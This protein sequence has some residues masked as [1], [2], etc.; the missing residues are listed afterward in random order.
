MELFA[1]KKIA[2]LL[3]DEEVLKRKSPVP[4]PAFINFDGPQGTIETASQKEM[5]L[6]DQKIVDDDFRELK[7]E[8]RKRV[9]DMEQDFETATTIVLGSV[10]QAIN[11]ALHRIQAAKKGHSAE[12]KFK[13]IRAELE[14]SYGPHSNRD[15]QSLMDELTSLSIDSNSPKGYLQDFDQLTLTLERIQ[16]R[17]LDGTPMRGPL[18][19][20]PD[21]QPPDPSSGASKATCKLYCQKMY[22]AWSERNDKYPD[23]GPVLTY[24]P[25]ENQLRA[26]IMTAMSKSRIQK[27]SQYYNSLLLP[28]N[29]LKPYEDI[30]KALKGIGE[31]HAKDLIAKAIQ[32]GKDRSSSGHRSVNNVTSQGGFGGTSGKGS[33]GT[34]SSFGVVCKNCKG[35]HYA[36]VCP[37]KTC[38]T[39]SPPKKFDSS[40]DRKKHYQSSH[41]K[42]RS[43]AQRNNGKKGGS[44]SSSTNKGK[45]G[46]K[47]KRDGTRVNKGGTKGTSR[48]GDDASD[49]EPSAHPDS[50]NAADKR[51]PTRPPK[52]VNRV[53]AVSGYSDTECDSLSEASEPTP[54]RSRTVRHILMAKKATG[55]FSQDWKPSKGITPPPRQGTRSSFTDF[56]PDFT[57]LDRTFAALRDPNTNIRLGVTEADANNI[58]ATEP[59]QQ[60]TPPDEGPRIMGPRNYQIVPW[61][62]TRF[63]DPSWYFKDELASACPHDPALRYNDL[64]SLR[65]QMS[66]EQWED[67]DPRKCYRD[68]TS[69]HPDQLP[70]LRSTFGPLGPDDELPPGTS[71]DGR[72]NGKG[73]QY[74]NLYDRIQDRAMYTWDS[75]QGD[76]VRDPQSK[77]DGTGKTG[78]ER[79]IALDDEYARYRWRGGVCAQDSAH[80]GVE[81]IYMELP[82]PS[83]Y[84][85]AGWNRH[86]YLEDHRNRSPSPRSFKDKNYRD[87]FRKRLGIPWTYGHAYQLWNAYR[88]RNGLS[89]YSEQDQQ[90]D[91]IDYER[92]SAAS[93][94][95]RRY[96]RLRTLVRLHNQ[97]IGP[98]IADSKQSEYQTVM[99]QYERELKDI[100]A[101]GVNKGGEDN[102]TA[103]LPRKPMTGGQPF[104][105]PMGKAP[106]RGPG[107]KRSPSPEPQY[108]SFESSA[109]PYAVF[110]YRPN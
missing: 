85:G 8:N 6:H 35:Q 88:D 31:D 72:S 52:K 50:D 5:R 18:P 21:D 66:A 25:E 73:R 14:S 90:R 57:S 40:D 1:E 107:T 89:R 94:A 41:A 65:V 58:Q 47:T 46:G 70:S 92:K 81:P 109:T 12:E 28:E 55:P 77:D 108:Q 11:T 74:R 69:F 19:P 54:K 43:D 39:C 67:L 33:G 87:W 22:N 98:L 38:F 23:G 71:D 61:P 96:Q 62:G 68:L 15:V 59:A 45:G 20:L 84:S 64:Y 76:I 83:A 105:F 51:G 99:A 37:S 53:T 104:I 17:A 2:Y 106:P 101:A 110:K 10:D 93:T 82:I 13:A 34:S 7:R 48:G 26:T 60:T 100:D 80:T 95:E 27:V 44:N 24:K 29:A 86:T 36:T 97:R 103:S 30:Y 79:D 63:G 102:R 3:S 91:R 78:E 32:N 16:K 42:N 49:T 4:K 75:D 56:T 9:V